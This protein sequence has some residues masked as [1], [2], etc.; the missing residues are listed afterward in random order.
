[1]T[2]VVKGDNFIFGSEDNPSGSPVPVGTLFVVD[3]MRHHWL[4]E[5]DWNIRKFFVA[6][7]WE[8]GNDEFED[9]MGKIMEDL[10]R[11]ERI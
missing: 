1:L 2:L 6:V 10:V 7:Q 9:T 3:P 8:I 4:Y 5:R 11:F